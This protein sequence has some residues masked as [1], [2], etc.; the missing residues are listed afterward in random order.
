MDDHRAIE[1]LINLYGHV[2]DDK[3]WGRLDEL[4]APD[5]AFL[6]GSRSVE[7]RGFA[8][9]DAHMRRTSH[10]IAHFATNIVVDVVEGAD[11]ATARVKVWAPRADGTAVVGH[12]RDELVRTADGWRFLVRDVH[13][14]EPR[15]AG[16]AA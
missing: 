11:R 13:L 3:D 9:V 6:I 2:L 5:G 10:P 12:Y 16:G 7:C 8:E 15:W 14:T 4:F 1:R